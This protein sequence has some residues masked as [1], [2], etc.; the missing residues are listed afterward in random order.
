MPKRFDS[1]VTDFKE[2]AMQTKKKVLEKLRGI[3]KTEQQ[4]KAWLNKPNKAFDGEK[5]ITIIDR[6]EFSR[7]EGMIYAIESG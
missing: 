3:F 1:S 6:K 2:Q 5:P 7:I 4:M